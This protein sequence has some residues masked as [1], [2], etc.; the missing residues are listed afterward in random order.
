MQLVIICDEYG[1]GIREGFDQLHALIQAQYET[2]SGQTVS[3]N[4]AF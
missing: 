4:G 2:G 1:F 3:V